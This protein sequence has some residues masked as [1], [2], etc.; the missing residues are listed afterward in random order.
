MIRRMCIG[1]CSANRFEIS[2]QPY[3]E[4][5][6]YTFLNRVL[7][8]LRRIVAT[9]HGSAA[10][11]T[12]YMVVND[13]F[14][15][16]SESLDHFSWRS[17]QYFGYLDLMPV[18]GFDG[19]VILDYGC[20][21]GNDLVGFANYSKP[22]KLIGVDVSKT[23]LKRAENRLALHGKPVALINIDELSNSI[24]VDSNSVDY[25]HT[26]GVLHHCTNLDAVLKEFSRI[27]KPDGD[28]AV[29]VYNY[30]SIWLHLNAAWI[31]QLKKSKHVG[32]TVLEA[33]R[34]TT[35]GEE[36]PLANCYRPDE[37]LSLMKFYGFEGRF[38]GAAISLHEMKILD[39]RYDAIL[40]RR[41]SKEHRDF[42]LELTFDN[43]GIP[44]YRGNVAGIDACYLFKK[45][46]AT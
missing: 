30:N 45:V 38:T 32:R 10:Y 2:K 36:C 16:P 8:K 19:K 39:Q 14:F 1:P 9:R 28:L 20:G 41:L 34:H 5:P 18:A 33:F 25:I 42:L 11:W 4:R 17:S 43:R 26:S 29:M 22:A 31:Y 40:D 27:L 13:T 3:D 21:P 35:D 12:T 37:F 15:S 7:N 23:A 6:M 44:Y 46:E 24:P